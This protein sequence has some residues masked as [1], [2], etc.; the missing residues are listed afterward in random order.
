MC[1]LFQ[2]ILSKHD[3]KLSLIWLRT[4]KFHNT[5]RSAYIDFRG[6][7]R[8][9]NINDFTDMGRI[10]GETV[11]D[12][13][14]ALENKIKQSQVTLGRQ[15]FTSVNDIISAWIQQSKN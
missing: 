14:T 10:F 2:I 3:L 9:F 7:S 12:Y 15:N 5:F 6:E 1:Q 8:H 11:L 13:Q 4:F